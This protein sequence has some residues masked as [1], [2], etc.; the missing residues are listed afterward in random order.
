[1]PRL[2]ATVRRFAAVVALAGLIAV[3]C[4][5][6]GDGGSSGTP[7]SRSSSSTESVPVARVGE[8]SYSNAGLNA[9]VKFGTAGATLTVKNGTGRTIEKPGLYVEDATS[10]KEIDGKV[11]AASTIPDGKSED[12][13]VTFPPEVR[14]D[15]IGLLILLIGPDNYG[16][17]VPPA[18]G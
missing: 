2:V 1:M 10:G 3:G 7:S 12:F 16:A 14:P 9:T 18:A 13:K 11:A 17:F 4:T 8:Y 5:S 15:T 6:D